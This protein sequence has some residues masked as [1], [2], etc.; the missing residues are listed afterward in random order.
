MGRLIDEETLKQEL[1]Q[2][3]FM[4]ILLTQN[5]GKDMF[6]ALAQKIDEIPTAYDPD[7]V[8]EQ[9]ENISIT[10]NCQECVHLN[11]CDKIQMEN[12]AGSEHIDLCAEVVKTLAIEIVKGGGVDGN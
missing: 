9:L 3:W 11:V 4:D 10:W 12:G 1:Y 2:Q 6:Y 5:S 8:V 7:K